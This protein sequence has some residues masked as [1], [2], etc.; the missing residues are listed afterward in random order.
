MSLASVVPRSLRQKAEEQP[1]H[2]VRGP[3]PELEAIRLR[4]KE[5]TAS[6]KARL[7]RKKRNLAL[8]AQRR[9]GNKQRGVSSLYGTGP[10]KETSVYKWPLPE[11][12]IDPERRAQFKTAEH[13]GLWGFFNK[14]RQPMVSGEEEAAFG[15]PWSYHELAAKDFH[16]L[17][18]LYW[19]TILEL[20]RTKTRQYEMRRLRAGYGNYEAE[21]RIQ[22]LEETNA[23]IRRVLGDRHTAY[24]EAKAL[25]NRVYLKDLGL[26]PDGLQ[27][28]SKRLSF[29]TEP[30]YPKPVDVGIDS[31]PYP[32][33]ALQMMLRWLDIQDP[34]SNDGFTGP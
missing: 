18:R 19:T 26:T 17:H 16:D 6:K 11:P 12:V 33:R 4:R 8:R 24:S 27:A 1:Q 10:R 13:H 15:R 2:E 28:S 7:R 25:V 30:M 23:N 22:A 21:T 3:D 14:A 34:R 9:D 32:E 20:N 5:M 31:Y 29:V